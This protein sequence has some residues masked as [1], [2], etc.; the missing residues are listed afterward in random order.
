MKSNDYIDPALYE[1][2]HFDKIHRRQK[3]TCEGELWYR[4]HKIN[5]L[6]ENLGNEL[7]FEKIAYL[8]IMGVLPDDNELAEFKKVLG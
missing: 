1:E 7:G 2:N 8:L 4:G 6:I 3:K 5:G